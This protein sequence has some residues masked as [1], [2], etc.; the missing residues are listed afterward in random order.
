MIEY[1]LR[2]GDRA[3]WLSPISG[4]NSREARKNLAQGLIIDPSH[5]L[6]LILVSPA[7]LRYFVAGN[8]TILHARMG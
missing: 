1:D 5:Q 7:L 2:P 4:P 8:R 3:I 6:L